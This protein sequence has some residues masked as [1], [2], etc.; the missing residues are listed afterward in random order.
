[1]KGPDSFLIFTVPT[2][3]TLKLH[4]NP[5]RHCYVTLSSCNDRRTGSGPF[6]SLVYVYCS[7]HIIS[8]Q[9]SFVISIESALF[10]R[11]VLLLYVNEVQVDAPDR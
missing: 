7:V 3:T 8:L 4:F 6:D 9:C 2:A 10:H 5:C 1:L 11:L